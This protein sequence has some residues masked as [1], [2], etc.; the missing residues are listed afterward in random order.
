MHIHIMIA[1]LFTF[2][3]IIL[4]GIFFYDDVSRW[5][6]PKLDKHIRKK[7][8]DNWFK[9]YETS[10]YHIINHAL[11]TRDDIGE[12]LA[13]HHLLSDDELINSKRFKPKVLKNIISYLSS[14]HDMSDTVSNQWKAEQFVLDTKRFNRFLT[15]KLTK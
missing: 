12:L 6:E 14:V 5:L 4:L 13:V 1:F 10:L 11:L 9:D 7:M 15:E 8:G 3:G 2:L